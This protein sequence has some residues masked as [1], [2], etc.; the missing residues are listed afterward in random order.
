M[1]FIKIF[2]ILL[3]LTINSSL[4]Q[5]GLDNPITKAMMNVYQQQLE[6][7]PQD[8]E[9]YFKRANEYYNHNLYLKALSDIN[10]A[11]KYIPDS[12]KDMKF[13]SLCMRASIYEV[14][15][16]YEKALADLNQAHEIDPTS[17]SVIYRKA[18]AEYILKDYVSAKKDYQRMLRINNRSVEALIG[19]SR[20][21]VIEKNLGQANEYADN[22]VAIAPSDAEA[23]IRRASV[24]KMMGN[25]T[26]AVDDLILALSTGTNN[27]KAL[28]E[29]VEM[30]NTDY[31]AVMTGLSNA[32]KQAPK[33]GMFYY[34]R[35][36]IAETHFNYVAALNDFK[37]II[38]ENL[39][40]YHGIYKEISECQYALGQYDEAIYNINFAINATNENGE[41]YVV[42]AKILRALK[43]ISEAIECCNI[44]LDKNP[45][46]TEALTIK[47]LC[48]S[49]S[50]EYNEAVA[51]FGEAILNHAENPY[52]YIFRAEILNKHLKLE[53]DAQNIYERVIDMDTD[54]NNIK[55]LRGFALIGI[56]K[57]E[58]AITWFNNILA[59][60]QDNDGLINY[61]GACLYAHIGDI[62][63]S[64]QCMKVSLQKGYSNYHN[65][66][67][68]NDAIINISPIRNDPQFK[69]LL[70]QY[71]LLFK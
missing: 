16:N 27:P 68:N 61:Y 53:I 43:C 51:L 63:K 7:D 69:E 31:N 11:L 47:G 57:K 13:Q 30:G 14:T 40:N 10:N 23:Y 6:E 29:L 3:T 52:N 39:Y 70:S 71:S 50:K 26:G 46:M 12:D 55:S 32:I 37:K 65:W 34:I 1:K 36:I 60:N 19:L 15:E 56:G 21:S 45:N 35:G 66:T 42:K 24:R 25:N 38:N 4:A 28:H 54:L 22:A 44:A 8:Y 67:L 5:E 9:T 20:I 41:Y 64:L 33:V 48:M 59:N 18:N 49:E 62:E 58:E 2:F 17:F